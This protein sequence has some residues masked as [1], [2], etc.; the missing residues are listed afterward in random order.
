MNER[1]TLLQSLATTITD[2]QAGEIEAPTPQ[3]VDR[4]LKQFDEPVQ[5]PLLRELDHVLTRTYFSRKEVVKFLRGL[6][7]ENKLAGAS[8]CKYW[9]KA[10]FLRIQ[11]NGHSQEEMLTV[12]D[13]VLQRTCGFTTTQCS[14]TGGDFIYLDD[15]IFTGGRVGEDL[16]AWIQDKAPKQAVVHVVVVATYTFAEYKMPQRIRQ[17]ATEQNKG[18]TLKVWRIAAFENRLISRD[19][20]EVLWPT[21][22]PEDEELKAYLDGEKKFP[23]KPRKAGGKTEHKIFSSEQGRQLLERELLLAGMR[24]RSFSQNP[25]RALRPLGFSPFGLGFG[26]MIVTF[27]NC[28]NNCPLA[29]WWGDPNASP[30]HPFSKWYPLLPRKTYGAEVDFD[31]VEF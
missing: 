27:R 19:T 22:V 18:I 20:S 16:A 28:P 12:F 24:I 1:R 5:L 14:A 25:S 23:F 10:Q 30:D 21:E 6:A 11:Q 3:H 9:T 4:W 2:Y 26:S 17:V 29:L 13:E 8:P 7:R 15:A 31:A